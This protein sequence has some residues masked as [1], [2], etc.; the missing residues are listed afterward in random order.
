MVSFALAK[1]IEKKYD[2]RAGGKKEFLVFNT[3]SIIFPNIFRNLT[4]S[5]TMN[6]P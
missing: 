6:L 2:L 4:D 3:D 5:D 1:Q